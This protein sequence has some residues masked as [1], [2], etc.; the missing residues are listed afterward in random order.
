MCLAANGIKTYVFDA[1]R[2]TP[3]LSFTIRHLNCISGINITAS[4]NPPAYN[5]YKA[6]WEDGALVTPPHDKGIMD[7]VAKITD[8]S[9]VKTMSKQEAIQKGL[10]VLIGEE[11]DR[12]Y[13]D[14]LKTNLINLDCIKD[15]AKD[16]NIVYTPLNGA[17]TA[18]VPNLL[19]ELGFE[20][21]NI[22]KEQQSPDGNFPT[23][24]SPNPESKEAFTLALELAKK[25]DADLILATDPDADRLGICVKDNNKNY[26]FFTG[27]MTGCLLA[28][29]ILSQKQ[30][31]ATLPQDGIVIKTIVTTN[32]VDEIVS[33]Y[34]M[35]LREVLTG[36]K[37]I[38][39]EILDI[40]QNNS[41]SF[42]FGYEESYG[43]STGMSVR[44][45]DSVVSSMLC[46]E[47]LAFCKSQNITIWDYMISI[48]KKY[49]YFI[50]ET[51]SLSFDGLEGQ[52]KIK[53]IMDYLRN[54]PLKE[55]SGYKV[56]NIR[57]Y[58]EETILDL[59]T[60]NITKT[61]LPNSNVLYYDLE[62]NNWLAVR[63]SG[64]EPK[65]KFYFGIKGTSEE[66]SAKKANE[67]K[68]ELAKVI[69]SI[70]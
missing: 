11:L 47:L 48:Y 53:G 3:E 49:G 50:E 42:L 54:N 14:Y 51:S 32:L 22:V 34:N 55:I 67:F 39:K 69:N 68:E 33:N 63:P 25:V 12:A 23:L 17:G 59:A 52:E 61:N 7:E 27:N 15:Y 9:L 43:Y 24:K 62:N 37:W 21:I 36:F 41:G 6:Y 2:P 29:Y 57:D 70:V 1:L 8:F 4:H 5:G 30:K 35:S 31:N 20:N 10:Y 13:Y 38:G 40:E 60:N 19:K 64:T 66:D 44:D 65:I 58:K 26:H 28:E 18:I 16:A 46:C 45:K 56:T